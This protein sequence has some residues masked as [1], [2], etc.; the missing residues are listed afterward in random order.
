ME[1]LL[2]LCW[3]MLALPAYWIWRRHISNLRPHRL[4]KTHAFVLL[5]SVLLLLFPVISA[6][7]DLHAMR[8]EMEESSPS[9][10]IAKHISSNKSASFLS[11][12]GIPAQVSPFAF[13]FGNEFRG[14][15][16]A[17]VSLFPSR[18]ATAATISRGPPP[19]SPSRAEV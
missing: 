10:Q 19:P 8:P 11:R 9:K 15:I 6:T 4:R 7:D 18:L 16:S 1:L 17:E 14:T 5:G 12:I 13:G 2:N 3:L